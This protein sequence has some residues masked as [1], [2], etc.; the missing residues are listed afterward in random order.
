MEEILASSGYSR[1][2]IRF[3]MCNQFDRKG[4]EIFEINGIPVYERSL[5]DLDT[6]VLENILWDTLYKMLNV[7]Y[8]S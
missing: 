6:S 8:S 5:E 4:R 7:P 2:E 1:E 3:Y